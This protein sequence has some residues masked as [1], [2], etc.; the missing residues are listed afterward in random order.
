M[1]N[2]H[3]YLAEP[4]QRQWVLFVLRM[5]HTLQSQCCIRGS[6]K[7]IACCMLKQHCR[8]CW[9]DSWIVITIELLEATIQSLFC[10][11]R[12]SSAEVGNISWPVSDCA[13]VNLYMSIV[14][15][16]AQ[17]IEGCSL[18][19]VLKE[20]WATLERAIQTFYRQQALLSTVQPNFVVFCGMQTSQVEHETTTF[21][22]AINSNRGLISLFKFARFYHLAHCC[23]WQ[24]VGI[25]RACQSDLMH[26]FLLSIIASFDMN[27]AFREKTKW[28]AQCNAHI[29][30]PISLRGLCVAFILT[31]INGPKH[32]EAS[33]GFG[34]L[35]QC[36]ASIS[37][38]REQMAH[39]LLCH[40]VKARDKKQV[41]T[42]AVKMTPCDL[43]GCDVSGLY[44]RSPEKHAHVQLIFSSVYQIEM[45]EAKTFVTASLI[46]SGYAEVVL[47]HYTHCVLHYLYFSSA[48]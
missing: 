27:V 43:L 31:I 37:G 19:C 33:T 12:H 44:R 21:S 22:R 26:F 4:T 47:Y 7:L 10:M 39:S 17:W 45:H 41:L 30:V 35:V 48:R 11:E 42:Q 5:R 40:W 1:L 36:H 15:S 46:T 29:Q 14:E 3:G 16:A 23:Y 2:H 32:Y 34:A 9:A 28:C 20:F 13:E 24:K 6:S 25:N 8:S 18:S 38:G